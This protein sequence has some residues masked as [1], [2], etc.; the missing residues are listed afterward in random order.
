VKLIFD[1]RSRLLRRWRF[2]AY[3][4]CALL[5]VAAVNGAS[6][7]DLQSVQADIVDDYPDVRHLDGA[8]LADRAPGALLFDVREADEF[9]VSH[10]AGA[11][12]LDPDMDADD[13]MAAYGGLIAGRDVVFYCS[14]GVRSWRMVER[15]GDRLGAAQSVWNLEGGVFAWHN[16]SRPLANAD[17]ATDFVHPYNRS[18][19]RLV[20]RSAQI[21]TTP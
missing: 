13:F 1:H 21:K 17:G 10:L 16:A 5:S 4:F 6:A 20:D 15:L 18:W 19:G 9:A 8:A 7:R 14:V 11:R 3:A 2:S 12:R